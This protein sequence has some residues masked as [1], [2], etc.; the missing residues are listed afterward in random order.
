MGVA[1]AARFWEK[2]EKSPGCWMWTGNKV[3]DK[4][5][6]GYERIW[7]DGK[8]KLA[9]RVSWEMVSGPIP[10]GMQILHRCDNP[11]CVRP[12]HLFM[13]TRS[14]NMRDA[15]AKRRWINVGKP[16]GKQQRAKTY[17]P[18]GHPYSGDNL[19]IYPDGQ[20]ACQTCRKRWMKEFHRRQDARLSD[21]GTNRD[22]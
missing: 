17:C 18:E 6:R 9:H 15:I 19:Y 8:M 14:D 16:R 13:G 4:P 1:L 12:D 11:S 5:N 20:R 7:A 10:E 3:S 21:P 22:G 2:V